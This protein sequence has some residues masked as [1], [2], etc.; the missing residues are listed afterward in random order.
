MR[1]LHWYHE[2]VGGRAEREHRMSN[3]STARDHA[4]PGGVCVVFPAVT[5]LAPGVHTTTAATRRPVLDASRCTRG[6]YH[7]QACGWLQHLFQLGFLHT[8]R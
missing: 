6:L 8:F 1:V 3:E 4:H 2:K 7:F 5:H